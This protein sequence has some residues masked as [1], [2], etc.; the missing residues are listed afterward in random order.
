MIVFWFFKR[1]SSYYLD[2]SLSEKEM[3]QFMRTNENYSSMVFQSIFLVCV[4]LYSV[5][6]IFNGI[7]H[8]FSKKN[9]FCVKV[10]V[11]WS[12]SVYLFS[13]GTKGT[14]HFVDVL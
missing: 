9:V 8:S 10:S 1:F 12:Y 3:S 11:Y 2:L 7:V 14:N 5:S 6:S 13:I 4:T